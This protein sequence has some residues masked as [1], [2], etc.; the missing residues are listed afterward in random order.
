LRHCRLFSLPEVG[1]AAVALVSPE[2]E[3]EVV[4]VVQL[5]VV[6]AVAAQPAAVAEALVLPLSA[7]LVQRQTPDRHQAQ[8]QLCSLQPCRPL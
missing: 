6:E 1:A 2:L 5:V 7:V 8:L 3:A 4:A